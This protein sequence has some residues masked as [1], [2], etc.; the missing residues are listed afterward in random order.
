ME[1]SSRTRSQSVAA[2]AY[3]GPRRGPQILRW[4]TAV[5]TLL[6]D[7]YRFTDL[8]SNYR[9]AVRLFQCCIHGLHSEVSSPEA[10]KKNGR[11]RWF[12][13]G[14][15]RGLEIWVGVKD[16]SGKLQAAAHVAPSWAYL[17][18]FGNLP[19]HAQP[20]AVWTTRFLRE[21]RT[22][23]EFA[24]AEEC[25]GRG[26]GRLLEERVAHLAAQSGC[27]YLHGFSSEADKAQ[28][29]FESCGYTVM[30]KNTGLPRD[31]VVGMPMK[32][33][34]AISGPGWWFYRELG[35]IERRGTSGRRVWGALPTRSDL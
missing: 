18:A 1:H 2:R 22:I 21:A 34:S 27:R 16:E 15:P 30:P 32:H 11:A 24:V 12:L 35:D 17:D 29:F 7:G 9:S 23:Q 5:N 13:A 28:G 19:D 14:D 3:Q 25:R 31:P 8:T 20:D 26:I 10:G 4:R 6:P 33:D